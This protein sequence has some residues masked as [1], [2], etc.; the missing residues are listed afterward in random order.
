MS[1]PLSAG[2]CPYH[3]RVLDPARPIDLFAVTRSG[4]ESL[5]AEELRRLGYDAKP[6]QPGRV[7]FTGDEAA[8]ARANLYL[9]TA[10]RVLIRAAACE[11]KDFGVLFDAAAAVEWERWIPRGWGFPVRGRCV[12]SQLSSA[13]ACQRLV[14]KAIVERLRRAWGAE[15]IEESESQIVCEVELY[16]DTATLTLDTTG[17]SLHKRG[18]RDLVT[19]APLKENLA[20]ALVMLSGWHPQQPFIDPFCGSGTLPIE[21]ALLARN[22]APG[23]GRTFASES[24]PMFDPALWAAARAEAR[25]RATR[26]GALHIAGY[27]HDEEALSLARR[28]AH[29]AGVEADI[30]FQ[31]RS[32]AELRAGREGGVIVTNPPWGERLGDKA[33][34]LRLYE[35]MPDVFNRFP[36]WTIGVITPRRDFE[37]VVGRL[38]DRRRKLHN[39]TIECGYYLFRGGR[40]DEGDIPVPFRGREGRIE[41]PAAR[42]GPAPEEARADR[43]LHQEELFRNRLASRLKHLRKWAT[44]EGLAC[45]R[46]YDRDIPEVPLLV[47]R[48]GERL[49][50]V[51]HFGPRGGRSPEEHAA[52]IDRMALATAESAD[53]E[54]AGVMVRRADG[55]RVGAPGSGHGKLDPRFEADERGERHAIDLARAAGTGLPLEIRG[56]RDVVRKVCPGARLLD[57]AE[58]SGLLARV[59]QASGAAAAHVHGPAP[60][61]STP[62]D[63]IFADVRAPVEGSGTPRRERADRPAG[64]KHADVDAH[65]NDV[66]PEL[67]A[68]LR[69]LAPGGVLW[70][71]ADRDAPP[72]RVPGMA[73]RDESR[74][75]SQ[76]DLRDER[77]PA[78]WKLRATAK[79]EGGANPE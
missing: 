66:G 65:N 28:H 54:L 48:Y 41:S 29:R 53:V 13:P 50:I 74:R 5:A 15:T 47:E 7:L 76:P 19:E 21:A 71:V 44:R 62:Y 43:T 75:L 24:W 40:A 72:P 16:Q 17:P 36:T 59:A 37:E 23:L 68:V 6:T 55:R 51:D 12:R 79:S 22:I 31:R 32:F 78:L 73:V 58:P 45:Y 57:A 35:S 67:G 8:I 20:A 38:A 30:H 26:D 18:Y 9:R 64:P 39:G 25:D 27:D 69:R 14:K 63:H 42:R 61:S 4:L 2:A 3:A 11:A 56:L 70:L 10:D 49:L 33:E 46:L 77:L 34:A 1:R 52:W 60:A